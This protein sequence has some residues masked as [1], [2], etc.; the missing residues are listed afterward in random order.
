MSKS[1][2]F[3]VKGTVSNATF[4]VTLVLSIWWGGVEARSDEATKTIVFMRHAEKPEGGLG[5]LNCRG[6]NRALA[7]PSV[8]EK[9]FG[10]PDVIMVPKPSG[11][12]EDEGTPYY[13]VRPLATVEPTAVAFGL[14]V[15]VSLDYAD[16]QGLVA[17]LQRP[18]SRN[19]LI[20]VAWEHNI[21]GDAARQLLMARGGNWR[22]VPEKWPKDD[23]DSMYVVRIDTNGSTF[24]HEREHLDQQPEVCPR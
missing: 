5:Q 4:L 10:K 6:L 24:S 2:A 21:I 3:R 9:A 16:L 22:D 13:Y 19:T 8:I 23:F 7:L 20:L 1:P 15:D 12:K 17:A 11:L 18:V 14:P